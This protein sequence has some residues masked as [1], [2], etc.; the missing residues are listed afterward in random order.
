MKF[1]T[2]WLREW[3]EL[4]FANKV[5][6]EQLT[7]A[8]LEVESITPVAGEFTKVIIGK[9]IS[10]EQHPDAE[11][12]RVCKV[13]VGQIETLII[14]CGAANV[15][16][17]LKVPVAI[18]GAQLP[19]GMI[20]K[21]T[22]L[23][24]V[25][26]QGMICST[27]ELGLAE[28]SNG[29]MELPQDAPI[30]EDLR[31]WLQLDDEVMDIHFTPN[32][33]DCLS[34]Q[35]IAR[36][37]AAL[38]NQPWQSKVY[39]LIDNVIDEQL[40]ITVDAPHDC[41]HYLGRVI[42][43][44]KAQAQTPIW[45]VEKLRR[46]G[47]R[48]IHPIV[49]SLNYVMLELGQPL[50]AFDLAK[51]NK[52]INVRRARKNEKITLLNEQTVELDE[53]VLVVADADKVLAIAG[54][55][56]SLDSAVNE[57]TQD[58]FLESAFFTPL[59]IAGRARRYGLNTDAAYR[60][61]R[62]V[63]PK[64]ARQAIERASQLIMEIMGG[65]AGPI[66][67][68]VSNDKLP[69]TKTISLRKSRVLKILGTELSETNIETILHRLGMQLAKQADGWQVT[70]PS[71]R[72]DITLEE[73]LIEE[74]ARV[75]GYNHL[76]SQKPQTTLHFMA[77]SERQID[78]M[79]LRNLLVDRNYHEAITYS[80]ISPKLHQLIDPTQT[81]F[82]IINPI[83]TD[84]SVMRASLWPGLLNAVVHNQN[85]QKIRVRL[86]ES[87]LC[88]LQK[89]NSL[90]QE[91][92]LGGVITGNITDEQWASAAREVDFFDLKK[93]VESL[94]DLA[95]CHANVEFKQT[96]HTALHPGQSAE[97]VYNHQSIGYLGALHPGIINELALMGPVYV[98][99]LHLA[100][101]FEKEIPQFKLFSKFPAIRRDISFWVNKEVA[102]AD[103]IRV[104]RKTAGELLHDTYVF[105]IYADE[106]KNP[107]LQS[108]A[109]TLLLQH[110]ERTLIDSEVDAIIEKVLAA[111]KQ[112]YSIRLRD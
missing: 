55:M 28:T 11:R 74:I 59:T 92:M 5:L 102:Q 54:I 70:S 63:D 87:G 37:I 44:V 46:S 93:D 101:L 58:V 83:S 3:V 104:I 35:G 86:F 34:L 111:L 10:A 13:D 42:R 103:I 89:N 22:K 99:E 62:G 66:T 112:D 69:A 94:L 77:N 61:E 105:D 7:M 68:K 15:R 47:L 50:H 17:D 45:L 32:R 2:Q 40:P 41:P 75:Y 90:Q 84:L 26:S 8:G 60:F 18:I 110:H 97:I 49:D 98:F 23:R 79:R 56:G 21:E 36:E 38:T 30:G 39:H 57:Q 14:V 76:S 48:S 71:F 91:M 12:L 108:L 19:N 24:G 100:A 1:S 20:I 51:I 53:E 16:A 88:F 82:E 33:G 107:G 95:G 72:F 27:S 64:L 43:G 106:S 31:A 67:E 9:V 65:Q 96:K 85:R 52:T 4:P 80:F 6:A 25:L 78:L 81:P 109:F 29:I 73:D